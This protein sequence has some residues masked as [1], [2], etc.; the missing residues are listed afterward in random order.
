MS[1]K[2]DKQVAAKRQHKTELAAGKDRRRE[3]RSLERKAAT[4]TERQIIL[5]VCEGKNTEPSYFRKFRLANTTVKVVGEGYNT[6]SLVKRALQLRDEGRYDQVWCVFDADPKPDNPLQSQ[7][8]NEAITLAERSGLRLAYSNQAFEYW[9]IL[10]F[11]DHQ[12]GKMSRRDYHQKIN[13][14]VKKY[15]LS[16]DG[17]GSKV[18]S[19]GFFDLLSEV[20]KEKE[21]KP[22]TRMD[23]A[24]DRAKKIHGSKPHIN[25]AE[26]ESC[27]TV[28]ALVE[29]LKGFMDCEAPQREQPKP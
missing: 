17:K 20:I 26:E 14:Y 9:L 18:I 15:G 21:G 13:D 23:L 2:K 25:C 1:R 28:Y 4:L 19:Q 27:T 29:V 8:F 6:L 5:I 7:N 10:H 16:F 24:I 12:G 11:E 22:Y 3:Q